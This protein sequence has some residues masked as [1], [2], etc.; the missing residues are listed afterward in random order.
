MAQSSDPAI[1]PASLASSAMSFLGG[2]LDRLLPVSA[3]TPPFSTIYAFGD[4]LSDAGNVYIATQGAEPVSPPYSDGRFSN[5]PVWVQDL[6]GQLGLP[7]PG[8][9][10]AGGTDFAFGGAQSGTTPLHTANA[11]DLPAQLADFQAADP[12]PQP[13]ALYTISIGSDALFTALEDATSNPGLALA[14]VNAAVVNVDKFVNNL[15]ADGAKNVLLLSVPDLGKIPS[16]VSEGPVATA[17]ASSFAKLFNYR[18]ERHAS[19]HRR[20]GPAA[21]RHRRHLLAAQFRHR[22]PGGIWPQQRD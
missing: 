11:T 7:P 6:A 15:A 22:Q 3:P 17:A 5:G 13:N 19:P 21:S 14:D 12:I 1:T 16:I 20:R 4:S 18:G 2:S 9:S 8:P 10:L